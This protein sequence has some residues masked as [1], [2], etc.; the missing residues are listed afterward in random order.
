MGGWKDLG[1]VDSLR[2]REARLQLHWAAQA[3]SA[4]NRQLLAHQ[5]DFGEQSLAWDRGLLLQAEAPVSLRLRS[6][7]RFQPV[8]LVL[9]DGE[10]RVCAERPLAGKTLEEGYVWLTAEIE[11]RL[12]HSLAAPLQRPGEMPGHPVGSGAAFDSSDAA[13]FVELAAWFANGDRLLREVAVGNPGASEVRCWPHH[14]DLATLIAL[15]APGADPET[16]RSIGVGLSPGDGSRPEPYFYVTPWPYPSAEGLP[17][18]PGGGTWN[19]EGWV[20]AVL[21]AQALTAVAG[22]LQ[23]AR[24]REFLQAAVAACRKLLGG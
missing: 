4:P 15:D 8:G 9:V 19:T 23:E 3:A 10:D 18:L 6:G 1:T 12:G 22:E 21:E 7:L 16:A 2:R 11:A 17:P 14:F 20:G 24:A 13:A 5:P